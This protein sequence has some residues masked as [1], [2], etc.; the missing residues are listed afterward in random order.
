M[1]LKGLTKLALSG[2]AL[3][4]V[5]ATLGT[6]TYAWYVTNSEAKVAGV[7]GTTKA[8][9][10]GNILVA[11]KASEGAVNGHGAFATSITLDS[12]N[13]TATTG[14]K[15]LAP[16]LPVASTYTSADLKLNAAT[17]GQSAA[18]ANYSITTAAQTGLIDATTKWIDSKGVEVAMP[19]STATSGSIPYI[20]FDVWVLN[21]ASDSVY[22][23]FD[24]QNTTSTANLVNQLAYAGTGLPNNTSTA[25][26]QG[27]TFNANIVDALRMAYTQTD[28]TTTDNTTYTG[29]TATSSTIL[30][31]ASAA[32]TVT[33]ADG[34]SAA[35]FTTDGNAN[36]YYNAVLG[37]NDAIVRTAS[38]VNGSGKKQTI[39]VVQNQ[40]TKLSFYIWLEGSDAQCF[41]SVSGQSFNISL[42]FTK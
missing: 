23:E 3:A 35:T 26:K 8:G 2:V 30:D 15:G 21:T 12:G 14:A 27:E 20:Q 1:K 10:L 25:V 38:G 36:D 11:Q 34:I 19:A 18:A 13:I 22:F 6:S 5:A 40:E 32:K 4:A 9:G 39:T 7:I 41:D 24:I 33:Y 42:T 17:T 31:V 28:Y 29:T 16:V 37:Q